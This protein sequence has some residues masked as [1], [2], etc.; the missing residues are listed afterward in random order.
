[1]IIL[2]DDNFVFCR[3]LFQKYC[4]KTLL[5]SSSLCSVFKGMLKG[6]SWLPEHFHI[7][8]HM[9][10]FLNCCKLGDLEHV[11]SVH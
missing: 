2:L 9:F 5:D 4:N 3:R 6:V 8:T 1:M 11:L 10:K 7:K